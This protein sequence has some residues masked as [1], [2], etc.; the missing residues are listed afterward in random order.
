MK[1]MY[2]ILLITLFSCTTSDRKLKVLATHFGTPSII[3]CDSIQMES[4]KVA[5][6]WIDGTKMRIESQL[7]EVETHKDK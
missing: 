3:Y 6:V 1:Y 2:L 5:Y 7:I 4:T